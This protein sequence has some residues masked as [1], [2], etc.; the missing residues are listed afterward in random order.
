MAKK[1]DETLAKMPPTK[2]TGRALDHWNEIVPALIKDK[3]LKKI[4][5]PLIESACEIF[6]M[7]QDMLA[8][9]KPQD[10]L[11]FLKTYLSI[12]EKFGATKKSRHSMKME[13]K[14]VQKNS[15]ETDLLKDFKNRGLQ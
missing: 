15:E 13:E 10:A 8:G 5:V 12:M 7:Y 2:L 1:S 14:A 4:D 6:V 9:E 11:P 3:S